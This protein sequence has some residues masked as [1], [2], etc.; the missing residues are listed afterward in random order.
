MDKEMERLQVQLRRIEEHREKDADKKIRKM[1]KNA[2][3]DVRQFLGVEYAKLAQDG[4]LTYE[5]LRGKQEYARFL[6]LVQERFADLGA[7]EMQEIQKAVEEMYEAAYTGMVQA[8]TAAGDINDAK[9]FEAMTGFYD[10]DKARSGY[11]TLA[12][13][14]KVGISPEVVKAAVENPV[15]GLTLKDT[16]ER[17]RSEII[18]NIKRQVGV[19]LTNGDSMA[20]MA[21]RIQTSLEGDYKKAL[22]IARTEVHRVREAGHEDAAEHL[23]KVIQTG[24]SGKRL[25]KIWRTMRDERV[26]PQRLT[27]T[28]KGWKKSIGKGANHVKMDGAVVLADELFDLGDGN[29]TKAPGQSG[30]AGHDINCRCIV[31]YDLMTDAEYFAATGKHF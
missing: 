12:K 18:Y 15:H 2:L 28:K 6:E 8:V 7:Q 4:K 26:R 24:K 13:G 31:E 11:E 19:G 27:K 25:V 30:V 20:T 23:D 3:K 17:H 5:I 29:K 16:L 21:K 9:A 10:V 1:Y 14:L 22:T